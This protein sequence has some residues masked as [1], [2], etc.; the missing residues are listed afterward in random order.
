[1]K[2]KAAINQ[3]GRSAAAINAKVRLLQKGRREFEQKAAKEAKDCVKSL[4]QQKL[5]TKP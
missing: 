2:T 3:D 5:R 1:V 4:G